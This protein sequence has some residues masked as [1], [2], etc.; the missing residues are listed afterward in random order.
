MSQEKTWIGKILSAI[1]S[2]FAEN[3]Q[4]FVQKLFKKIPDELKEKISI[5][6]LIVENIK[7]FIDSPVADI[8]TAIIPGDLDDK[9]K[10]HLRLIL[11]LILEKHNII[12]Q[13]E[14]KPE[15][16]HI[17]ATNINQ[18]LTGLSFGQTALTTEVVYQNS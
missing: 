7:K 9:I 2:V 1:I 6:I 13:T 16:A 15:G 18:E 11:P 4:S 3:W 17:I 8:L 12:N 10:D 5:G 14:L